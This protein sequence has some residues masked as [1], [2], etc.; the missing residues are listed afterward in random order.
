MAKYDAKLLRLSATR[1]I[2]ADEIGKI[3]G[4]HGPDAVTRLR[5][6]RDLR[7]SVVGTVPHPGER[8]GG[9]NKLY[10]INKITIIKGPYCC[11]YCDMQRQLERESNG[12]S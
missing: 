7:V 5:G 6:R 8:R 11:G 3:V 1:P 10:T 9:P 2:T 4:C 12:R